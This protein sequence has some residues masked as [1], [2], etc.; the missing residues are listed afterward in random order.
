[1]GVS[2]L[3]QQ[4]R[5]ANMKTEKQ[6]KVTECPSCHSIHNIKKVNFSNT[7]KCKNYILQ[8]DNCGTLLV[9]K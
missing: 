6:T 2:I 9:K 5:E 1:M 4:K 3:K 8:C 7:V